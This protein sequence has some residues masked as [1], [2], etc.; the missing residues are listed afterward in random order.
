[1]AAEETHY[2]KLERMYGTAPCNEPLDLTAEIGR[3]EAR[4]TLRVEPAL[5]HAAHALHG[6]YLFK[7]MDDSAFF[8]CNSLELERFVLTVSFHV[9]LLRPVVDGT[10]V[11]T[12]T[13][14]QAGRAVMTAEAVVRDEQGHEVAR[15]S[16]T[17]ARVGPP[18]SAETGY[19]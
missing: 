12:A 18:L 14:V 13:V 5:H 16:G 10:L 1:M 9:H 19:R 8:A 3:G 2:R 7:L 15:G 6:S 4:I 11:A 17:F